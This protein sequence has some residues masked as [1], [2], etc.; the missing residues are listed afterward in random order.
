[1]QRHQ[2][3]LQ[4]GQT[5]LELIITLTITA[6]LASL[7]LPSF[8]AIYRTQQSLTAIESIIT[9]YQQARTGAI[10]MNKPV[11]FCAR[12]S[13]KI[14]GSDWSQGALVFIDNNTDNIIDD[15]ERVFAELPAF[16]SGSSIS[17]GTFGNRKYL[18]F[19][20][21]GFL[22]NYSAGNIV[23]CPPNARAQDARNLIFTRMGR[24]RLG[25]D[26]NGDGIREDADGQPLHCPA[27]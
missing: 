5:L 6:T 19:S 4:A 16:P 14:C 13:E 23:Y 1:M 15:G 21:N 24:P 22:E 18:R 25:T 7:A 10:M 17:I 20:P 26:S 3:A 8:A 2:G 27:G 11:T 9:A 12:K